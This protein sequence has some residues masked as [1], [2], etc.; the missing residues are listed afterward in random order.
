[1]N[2][3]KVIMEGKGITPA[4][5]S[6]MSGVAVTGLRSM[7]NDK[8]VT[9]Y[10]KTAQRLAH[11]LGVTP[12]QIYGV[13]PF[14]LHNKELLLKRV[15]E[16]ARELVDALRAYTDDPVHL[17]LCVFTREPMDQDDLAEP[18]FFNAWAGTY[19]NNT[20]D[21]LNS[22]EDVLSLI[23]YIKRTESGEELE[24]GAV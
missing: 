19:D 14:E 18:D 16:A 13:S 5:L 21:F 11:A 1:M 2:N 20:G 17:H 12:A 24:G 4:E 9:P 15:N 22:T 10:N 3:V 6:R 23:K 7:M 8:N